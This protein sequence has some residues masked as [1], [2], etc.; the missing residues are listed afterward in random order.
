[1]R[2]MAECDVDHNDVSFG[3]G[4]GVVVVDADPTRVRDNRF[5]QN[6]GEAFKDTGG[7]VVRALRG[8]NEVVEGRFE[9][10]LNDP[11]RMEFKFGRGLE[12]GGG[13]GDD[14]DEGG[15]EQSG[16]GGLGRRAVLGLR[17]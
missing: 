8:A 2:P 3:N 5:A 14:E 1:V 13:E 4:V 7:G 9:S 17:R 6:Y 15:V 16:G 12:E 10:F 11:S